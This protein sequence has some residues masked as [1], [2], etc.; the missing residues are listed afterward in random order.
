MRFSTINPA[1]GQVIAEYE[2]MSSQEIFSIAE[3]SYDALMSWRSLSLDDRIPY[4]RK[5]ASVLRAN[6]EEYACLM[7]LEMGKPITEALAEVEK[8]AWTAE[9]Y[10]DNAAD[11]L[12]PEKVEADG[13]AHRVS[14]EPLGVI[15]SVMPWNFPFWQALRFGI[16]TILAGNVSI[17]KH[18]N[19]V[20][21]CAL[22]IDDAF[23]QAGFPP[24]VFRT[25][26]A[27]H[28]SVSELVASDLVQGVSLTGSTAAGQS[29]ASQAGSHLKKVVLELGGSDPFI[30]LDDAD[31]DF[32]V[33]GAVVGRFLNTGQS[34]IASKRFIVHESVAGE[35]SRRF[36]ESVNELK[37][38]D[39]METDT[40]VGPLVNKSALEEIEAQV[41]DA[42]AKGAS[43]LTGGSVL[44]QDGYFFRPTVLANVSTDM[45][46][47]KEEVFG[48]VAPIITVK[49][50]A[51]AV[52]VANMTEFG[53]GGNVWTRDVERGIL[54]ANRI[55]AGTVF[56]NSITKSD[57]RM[58]F[59][60]IKKSGIGRELAKFGIREFVN[61]KALNV[62]E[63]P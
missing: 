61:V 29:I 17:L 56:V 63:H 31:I 51:E 1:T 37:V 4:F 26:I 60:G 16:P 21:Q 6:K 36:A 9:V 48:P 27:D 57:P 53:L 55:D 54:V 28:D 35:F 19:T 42:L 14:Y 50:D 62:Y 7:T 12:R 41:S 15:L 47:F 22:A 8:C 58:P 30:V 10:S 45:R 18:S 3:G 43:V 2:T 33:K 11:W 32:A 34:C 25:I 52:S 13:L 40:Q 49:D 38:G 39:P 44:E 5:L 20:P 23:L 46:V 59:G 24:G